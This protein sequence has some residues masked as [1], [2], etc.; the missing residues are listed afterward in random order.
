[1]AEWP[2]CLTR[3]ALRH[4]SA[5]RATAYRASQLFNIYVAPLQLSRHPFR[6][7]SLFLSFRFVLY[8]SASHV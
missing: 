2:E 7:V 5:A 3:A 6:F 8:F 4:N 1:M